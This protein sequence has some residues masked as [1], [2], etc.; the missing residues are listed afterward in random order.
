MTRAEL[1]TYLILVGLIAAG[2]SFSFIL[3]SPRKD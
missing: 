3:D 2:V 1:I